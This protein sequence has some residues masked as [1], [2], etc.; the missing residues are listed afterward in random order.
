MNL[1]LEDTIVDGEKETFQNLS[2]IFRI[3]KK[4]NKKN[5]PNEI[6]RIKEVEIDNFGFALINHKEIKVPRSGM[7]DW[8]DMSVTNET[9]NSR[10]E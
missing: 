3:Q 5:N 6:F 4:E 2:R 7:I 8:N 10:V 9:L 1:V